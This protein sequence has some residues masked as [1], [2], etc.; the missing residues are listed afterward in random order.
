MQRGQKRKRQE[1]KE[2]GEEKEKGEEKVI[3]HVGA[4]A[5]SRKYTTLRGCGAVALDFS[6]KHL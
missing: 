3:K 6:S 2:E 4:E 1:K 5:T